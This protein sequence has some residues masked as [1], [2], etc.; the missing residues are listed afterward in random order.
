MIEREQL[1]AGKTYHNHPTIGVSMR[2]IT[3]LS[4]CLFVSACA[5]GRDIYTTASY[6]TLPSTSSRVSVW[7]N[8]KLVLATAETWLRDRGLY[9]IDGTLPFG[10]AIAS[11]DRL[12]PERCDSA[13]AL[14]AAKAGGAD[15]VIFFHLS[16]AHTPERLL[17]VITGI[18]MTTGEQ[19]F[20]A[21]GTEYLT[22][23][24][25]NE[26][27]RINALNNI[28]CH[29]LATVWQYRPGGYPE[30]RSINYCYL[31]RLHA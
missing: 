25:S 21:D 12:C 16:T 27:D 6:S 23:P 30:D 2:D 11:S 3:L 13:T 31:P 1:P 5:G 18:S 15:Y 17:V 8:N 19:I 28:L 7:G 9:V 24:R 10:T 22:I 4:I 26:E 20:R 14:K 29:A